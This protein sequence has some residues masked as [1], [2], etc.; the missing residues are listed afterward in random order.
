MNKGFPNVYK[1]V[2]EKACLKQPGC[3]GAKA[4]FAG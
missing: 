3:P 4:W 1:K 2:N